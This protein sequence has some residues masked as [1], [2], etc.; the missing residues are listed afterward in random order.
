MHALYSLHLFATVYKKK[1]EIKDARMVFGRN[2]DGR[3]E[4]NVLFLFFFFSIYIL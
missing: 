3:M 2:K 1:K 4:L